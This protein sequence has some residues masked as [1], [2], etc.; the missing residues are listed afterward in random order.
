MRRRGA[1]ESH[2]R[3]SDELLDGAAAPLELRADAVVVRREER[4]DVLGIHR[5]CLC[6]EA[7]EVAEDDRDDLALSSL[8]TASHA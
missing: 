7:D 4:L 6:R 5:L 2:H 8:R 1:E 3:V